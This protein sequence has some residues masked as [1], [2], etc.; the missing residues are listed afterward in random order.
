MALRKGTYSD[1]NHIIKKTTVE[2]PCQGIKI[3]A[4]DL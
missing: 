1:T 4:M 2:L 3:I